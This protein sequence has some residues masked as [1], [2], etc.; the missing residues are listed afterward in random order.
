[1]KAVA[2]DAYTPF[3]RVALIGAIA[4]PNAGDEAILHENLRQIK[5]MFGDNCVVYVFTKDASYTAMHSGGSCVVP[6]DYLHRITRECGYNVQKIQKKHE[7]LLAYEPGSSDAPDFEA[8][9]R[10]MSSVDV[11]HIIGGGYINSIWPDMLE[12]V[13]VLAM[14]AKHYGTRVLATGIGVYPL[15]DL[16]ASRFLDV[17]NTCE[18]VDFRDGSVDQLT[19][20]YAA[21]EIEAEL[22][23]TTDDAVQY[24]LLAPSDWKATLPVC[25]RRS[26]NDCYANISLHN[27]QAI[28][29][30]TIA[31]E[32]LASVGACVDEGVVEYANLL[33]F[34]PSDR[35][36]YQA[37]L[38]ALGKQEGRDGQD[39]RFRFVSL[40][41][42]D[43]YAS[44]F[45]IAHA[46]FNVGTRY[47][48][49]AF[50]LASAVPVYS[51]AIN[52]Y[53]I[54]KLGTIH[55][56][57]QSTAYVLA[58]D[59]DADKLSEFVH[60]LPAIQIRLRAAAPEIHTRWSRKIHAICRVY[61]GE[62]LKDEILYYRAASDRPA[63]VSVIIPIYNMQD[64]L[65]QCLDSVL[66]QNI[67]DMEIICV[68]DGSSD[69]TAAILYGYAVKDSRVK[70]ITQKNQGVSAARNAGLRRA[71]GEFVF[72]IDPD[73][74]LASNSALSALYWAAKEHGVLASCG[75]F[76]EMKGGGYGAE[77]TNWVDSQAG[78][79]IQKEGLVS[80]RDFQFDYGWIR[81]MYDRNTL[82]SN[83]LWFE[84]RKFYEDPVWFARVMHT[85]GSFWALDVPVYCYRTGYKSST[86]SYDK[87]VDLLR[88]FRDNLVFAQEHDYEKL[89]ALTYFRI[90]HDYAG[91]ITPYLFDT[92]HDDRIYDAMDELE[93]AVAAGGG[94]GRIALQLLRTHCDAQ[95]NVELRAAEKRGF[96]AGL[97]EVRGS[98]TYKLGNIFAIMPRKVKESL[99]PDV[100]KRLRK[101]VNRIKKKL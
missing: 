37:A 6:I 24:G 12:E 75:K 40:V 4:N 11:L 20:R 65:R 96:R 99:P 56:M 72:F 97:A 17:V 74:W 2:E 14:L 67:D 7:E 52:Q 62:D 71:S 93:Q 47:H 81:F 33:V 88:G 38:E 35:E 10:I 51:I 23:V 49:A 76:I 64:Y 73:D 22:Q 16:T 90:T 69:N 87:V 89:W 42:M 80:Y 25:I 58:E 86:L 82:I 1:M 101:T 44:W 29:S 77:N 57:F 100:R 39:E 50:S 15:D 46:R 3:R 5:R 63:K 84:D 66:A 54:Y 18:I 98:K 91:I 92:A 34:D 21:D 41:D 48:Q 36:M 26:E 31:Q 68:D 70:I 95:H 55:G 27:D 61:A 79:K 83:D 94:D 28:T 59:F 78:Y 13:H 19:N 9:H 60:D 45:I 8:I 53:Y 85:M 32:I 43:P 30:A